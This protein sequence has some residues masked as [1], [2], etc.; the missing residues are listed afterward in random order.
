VSISGGRRGSRPRIVN[1]FVSESGWHRSIIETGINRVKKTSRQSGKASASERVAA[2]IE[3]AIYEGRFKP[4]ERVIEDDIAKQVG[5]SRGPVREALLRLE[6]D[7]L[8]VTTPRRGTVVRDF[9][10][11]E[12]EVVF[13]MRGKLEALCVRYL[14]ETITDETEPMLRKT[15]AALK[16][17]ATAGDY[18]AYLRADMDLHSTIWHL[19]HQPQLYR[20]LKFAMN[21]LFFMIASATMPRLQ[22]T[23]DLRG[24]QEYIKMILTAPIAKVEHGTEEYF[25]SEYKVLKEKVFQSLYTPVLT[26]VIRTGLQPELTGR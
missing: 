12:V 10:A 16:A 21:P 24:H 25:R 20:T 26:P 13:S 7:G 6:R 5:C 4:R 22:L 3:Q 1:R 23:Q 14:R 17:A 2:F 19:S 18:V 9:S 11:H 15:L 8:V